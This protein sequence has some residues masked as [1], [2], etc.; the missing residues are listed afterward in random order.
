LPLKDSGRLAETEGS[1]AFQALA[2]TPSV[3]NRVKGENSALMH[4]K[5][6]QID[7]RVVRTGAANFSAV[8]LKR[9]DNDL[10]VIENAE[11]P[12]LSSGISRI[13]SQAA[14]TFRS[15]TKQ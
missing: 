10:V 11:Q 2:E 13:D 3:E 9:G 12:R 6:Y 14:K 8:G 1:K 5:S 15:D 4:L 7:G